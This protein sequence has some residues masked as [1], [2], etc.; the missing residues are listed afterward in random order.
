MNKFNRGRGSLIRSKSIK[1][2]GTKKTG[3]TSRSRK[4]VREDFENMD[5]DELE[6]LIHQCET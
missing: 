4:S 6:N 2:S 1:S 3:N 5:L